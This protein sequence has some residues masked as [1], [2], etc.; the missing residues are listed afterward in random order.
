MHRDERTIRKMGN[1]PIMK[2]EGMLCFSTGH[3]QVRYCW[4]ST[5]SWISRDLQDPVLSCGTTGNT[6]CMNVICGTRSV[7]NAPT[8]L[9]ALRFLVLLRCCGFQCP[10]S[11]SCLA[12]LGAAVDPSAA[13]GE[14]C[15]PRH[16]LGVVR[17]TQQLLSGEK[18]NF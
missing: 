18:R 5:T 3:F 16:L 17:V 7:S 9:C 1:S 4:S 13:G 2:Q 11:R 6:T 10:F 15:V 14:S 8:N 12:R